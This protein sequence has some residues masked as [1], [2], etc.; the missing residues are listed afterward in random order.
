M[1]AFAVSNILVLLLVFFTNIADSSIIITIA[2]IISVIIYISVIITLI[3]ERNSIVVEC[4]LS[5]VQITKKNSR[6]MSGGTHHG[7]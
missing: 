3:I 2:M 6:N 7:R 4:E 5:H 1:L